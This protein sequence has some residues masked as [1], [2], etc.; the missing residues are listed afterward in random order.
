MTRGFYQ[1]AVV[2]CGVVVVALLLAVAPRTASGANVLANPGFETGTAVG[3]GD[4]GGS[5]NWTTF[6]NVFTTSSPNPL[7]AGPHSGTG[8]L[9]E[10]GTFPGVS[11][12]FQSFPSVP[13]DVWTLT[14]FGLNASTDAMQPDNFG[15]LK[16]SYQSASNTEIA[17]FESAHI[18]NLTPQ[19]QWQAL[20]VTA[21]APAGTTHVQLFAL[22][23]QPA[24]NG[25]AA[26]F[27]DLSGELVPEPATAGV[28]LLLGGL[29][30]VRRRRQAV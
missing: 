22:F 26:F 20:T 27:D 5:P 7:P 9:K 4:V 1:S 29:T 25:G 13:G 10:F 8:A 23:V 14:G 17:G 2:Q 11:G 24:T 16:I 30:L 3:N 18:T 15:L 28:A 12:A 6:G 19:N 21:T